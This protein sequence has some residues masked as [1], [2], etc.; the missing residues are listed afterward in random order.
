MF[1]FFESI[2]CIQGKPRNLNLHQ[3][4]MAQTYLDHF[5]MR[6]P[7][8]LASMAQ[9]LDFSPPVKQKWKC[10]YNEDETKNEIKSYTPSHPLSF[11]CIAT[12]IDYPYKYSD[13][14]PLIRIKNSLPNGIEPI[15]IINNALTD[16][17]YSN[18]IFYKDGK[19]YTS[20]CYLLRGTMRQSLLDQH[21]VKEC[22][23]SLS[24]VHTFSHFK[25]INALN[26]FQESRLYA[27]KM[28]KEY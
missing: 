20:E 13:R 8:D 5:G 11:A 18:L 12:K 2:A 17:S 27:T 6:C 25:C 14:S 3:A 15:I 22:H 4:R 23:I 26:S 19:W 16:T 28:I 1:P 7:F 24:N 10:Y 9:H 21:L